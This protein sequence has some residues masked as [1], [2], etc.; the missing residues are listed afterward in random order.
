M[1]ED[2]EVTINHASEAAAGAEL[3]ERLGGGAPRLLSITAPDGTSTTTVLVHAAGLQV[4]S[5]EPWLEEVR[6]APVRR[7]GTALLED[8]DSFIEH[9]NRF[10]DEGSVLFGHADPKAPSLTSVLDYH[11]S[12]KLAEGGTP[13]RF[14]QHRGLY[15]FPLSDEWKA[16]AEFN[17]KSMDQGLFA[18]FIENR[19]T[20]VIDPSAVTGMAKELVEGAAQL[21]LATP[22]NLVQLSHGLTVRVGSR[23]Q[24]VKTLQ[25]GAVS[26]QYD[27]THTDE[28]GAPL[29]IP[30]AFLLG[31]PVFRNGSPYQL[32]A[33]LRYRV[34]AGNVVWFYELYRADRIF[35]HAFKEACLEAMN[36]TALPLFLGAPES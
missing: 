22:S 7:R 13:P 24:N 31:L 1:S 6:K 28:N 23:V 14:G 27:T 4:K 11:P 35:D 10:K 34:T 29:S 36:E 12:E 8:L 25:S 32:A 16:W 26:M 33:R 3:V 20:D 2:C 17:G 30:S 15:R 18:E 5:I 19:I 21:S 9:T